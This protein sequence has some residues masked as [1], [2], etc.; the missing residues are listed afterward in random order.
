MMSCAIYKGKNKSQFVRDT[1]KVHGIDPLGWYV[2]SVIEAARQLDQMDAIV[3]FRCA[4]GRWG[5]RAPVGKLPEELVRTT[6][7]MLL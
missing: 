1:A 3:A 4:S 2:V 7:E 5:N 6:K